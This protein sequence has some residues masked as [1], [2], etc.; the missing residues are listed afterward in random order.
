MP[1]KFWA[2]HP[3][4]SSCR[5]SL[6]CGVSSLWCLVLMLSAGEAAAPTVSLTSTPALQTI[7]PDTDIARVTLAVQRDG[8]PLSHG[9]VEVQVTAPPRPTFLSTDF[10][11]VE[12]TTLLALASD[13][14]DGAFAFDYVFPIRGA[15][16]FDV[17][18]QPVEGALHFAPTTLRKSFQLRE[19]PAEVRNVWILVLG[20]FLL[21]GF[22][23]LVLARSATAKSALQLTIVLMSLGLALQAE[24]TGRGQTEATPP[25][26]MVR[27]ED[28]WELTVASTPTQGT[29]GKHVQFAM[30]LTKDG[31]VL[32]ETTQ[33]SLALHHI[34]DDTPIFKTD[35]YAPRGETVQ[36]VQFFDGAPH[37]VT[38]T[39]HPADR[40]HGLQPPLQAVFAMDVQGLQPP[41]T[42]KLRTMTLLV[43][44]LTIG[45][46]VGWFI[47]VRSKEAGSALVC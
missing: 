20:L 30:A 26:Q 5:W 19:N 42:V 9:H 46:V 3:P 14:R 38:I 21:G 25:P 34:E 31:A 35:I 39:A 27:G 15:Y 22:F 28:G 24:S 37:R 32:M 2:H 13:L 1:L 10:P 7:R 4:H 40:A 47:P 41:L 6:V 12:G 29:V 8:Q 11:M 18:L 45:M 23:G 33:F 16:T 36:R 44:V 43:G 17:T